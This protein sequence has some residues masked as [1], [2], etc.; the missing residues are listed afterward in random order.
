MEGEE[1][2]RDKI[3]GECSVC[4]VTGTVFLS[5]LS[6]YSFICARR[7]KPKSFHRAFCILFGSSSLSLAICRAF[8]LGFFNR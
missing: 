1:K 2:T 6:V 3:E 4:R 5:G 8:N 7:A